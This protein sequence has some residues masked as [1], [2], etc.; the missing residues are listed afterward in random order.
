M[1]YGLSGYF[2]EKPM[3]GS[4][5]YSRNL[6]RELIGLASGELYVFCPSSAS[7]EEAERLTAGAPSS[8][9]VRTV[10]LPALF[11]GNL[12]KLW[13]EQVALPRAC[14]R[15]GVELLHVPYLGSPFLKPCATVVTIHDLIMLVLPQHRGSVWVRLYTALACA[16]AKRADLIL[17]DSEHTKKDIVRLLRLD[18]AKIEVVALACE[19]RFRPVTDPAQ[20]RAVRQ[21][22]GLAEDFILYLGGLDWRKNVPTLIRAFSR[23]KPG[24]QLGIVG[25]APSRNRILFPDL[26]AE[27]ID[28]GV[29]GRIRF[30]GLVEEDDKPSLYSAARVFV[31]PSRYE[32]FGLPPLEAMACGTPVV[33]S[34]ASSL[35]EVVGDAA[36]LVPPEDEA[37]LAR[38]IA[39]AMEDSDQRDGLRRQGLERAALFSWRRTAQETLNAYQRALQP[40]GGKP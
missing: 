17:A 5:Q 6:L 39:A 20:L 32:G 37:G 8:L 40:K 22:Y 34:N 21:K 14:R 38:A 35:P 4:G 10:A 9:S 18:P 27:A 24:H 16:A 36:I 28:A 23:L 29:Q 15:F 25:E 1:R 33:C 26:K 12:G 30:T 3:T 11:P 19:G 31:Y 7:A 13:F 2:L